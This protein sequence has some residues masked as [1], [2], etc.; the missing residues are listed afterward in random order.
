MAFSKLGLLAYLRNLSRSKQNRTWCL[1]LCITI[2][3]WALSSILTIAFECGLPNPWDIING[4]CS[5]LVRSE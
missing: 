3:I 2:G 1:V 4:H 5:N